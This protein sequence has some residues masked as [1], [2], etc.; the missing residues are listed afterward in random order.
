MLVLAEA[1]LVAA[2]DVPVT[3]VDRGPLLLLLRR[4]LLRLRTTM[5]RGAAAAAVS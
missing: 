4:T 5:S 2:A 1:A 3:L